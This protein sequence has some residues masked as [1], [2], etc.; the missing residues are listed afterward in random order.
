MIAQILNGSIEAS[1]ILAICGCV[2]GYFMIRTLIKIDKNLDKH[3]KQINNITIIQIKMLTKMG[4][5]DEYYEELAKEL[6]DR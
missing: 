2:I 1:W 4:I 5:D 6:T 3:E